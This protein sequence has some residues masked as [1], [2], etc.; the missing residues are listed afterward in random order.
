MEDGADQAGALGHQR[1]VA[2]EAAV[3]LDHVDGQ[4][5]QQARLE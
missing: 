3:E 1:Q 4:A 2:D 5:A